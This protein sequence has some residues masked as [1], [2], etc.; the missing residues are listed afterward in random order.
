MRADEYLRP[1]EGVL[2]SSHWQTS[3]HCSFVNCTGKVFASWRT[4]LS[5]ARAFDDVCDSRFAGRTSCSSS[6]ESGPGGAGEVL[7]SQVHGAQSSECKTCCPQC[8][9]PY[10][11]AKE[12]RGC[13]QQKLISFSRHAECITILPAQ[14]ARFKVHMHAFHELRN[15]TQRN[16][17]QKRNEDCPGFLNSTGRL[18]DRIKRGL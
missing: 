8:S 18:K 1:V 13:E 9:S 4:S 11:K 17:K 15:E 14:R 5:R 10:R 6:S 7:T 3:A 16:A 2:S 12:V